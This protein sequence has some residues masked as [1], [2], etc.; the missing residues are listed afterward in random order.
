MEDERLMK[1]EL[2]GACREFERERAKKWLA[3]QLKPVDMKIQPSHV[4]I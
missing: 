4:N 1:G 3:G 2:A